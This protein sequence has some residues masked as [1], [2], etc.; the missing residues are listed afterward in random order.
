MHQNDGVGGG[1]DC[2]P[3]D[4]ARMNQNRVLGADGDKLMSFDALANVQQQHS[5]AFTF[6]VKVGMRGN[7]QFPI[8]GG[9]VGGLAKL[10]ALRRGTLAQ[11]HHLVFVGVGR[12][13]ERGNQGRK[14]R[15][16]VHGWFRR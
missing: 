1:R 6:R 12:K 16:G 3:E 11:G 5:K 8:L 7:V 13:L 15:S 10:D 14:F 9:L 2:Q 4:F